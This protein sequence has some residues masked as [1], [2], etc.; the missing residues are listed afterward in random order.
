MAKLSA[1]GRELARFEYAT[2]RV[3]YFEDG[4]ILRNC[5]DGWKRWKKVKAGLDVAAV[6][7]TRKAGHAQFLHDCPNWA[8]F[9]KLMKACGS[10]EK[11]GLLLCLIEMMPD[12]PDGIWVGAVD[13]LDLGLTLED[14][15]DLCDSYKTGTQERQE[16]AAR[17]KK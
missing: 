8:H 6:V 5:G 15:V 7:E 9:I 4:K 1:H 3:A 11:R 16:R 14:I 12:D 10:L 2:S 13:D 17:L